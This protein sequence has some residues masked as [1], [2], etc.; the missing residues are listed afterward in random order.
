MSKRF[1]NVNKLQKFIIT[2]ILYME[3]NIQHYSS[4]VM[5]RGTPCIWFL[6]G[7]Y[8][9]LKDKL[10][11]FTMTDTYIYSFREPK[12]WEKAGVNSIQSSLKSNS[13]WLNLYNNVHIFMGRLITYI[14][15]YV[16]CTCIE[17]GSQYLLCT[18]GVYPI[19][20]LYIN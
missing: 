7:I 9:V 20:T 10:N 12:I 18:N 15:V 19:Y 8:I 3:E 2:N 17:W 5:F 4:T 16:H 14:N 13:L 1:L 11:D 6:P